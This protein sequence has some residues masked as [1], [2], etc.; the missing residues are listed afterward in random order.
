MGKE[1]HTSLVDNAKS[2]KGRVAKPY[3][4]FIKRRLSYKRITT[5]LLALTLAFTA[6][7]SLSQPAMALK[8]GDLTTTAKA[9]A[10]YDGFILQECVA[11]SG[12][13]LETNET[14]IKAG[15]VVF[16]P[17]HQKV[18]AWDPT[19]VAAHASLQDDNEMSCGEYDEAIVKGAL[20]RL[21]ID[22]IQFV[23]SLGAERNSGAANCEKGSGDF[24]YNSTIPTKAQVNKVIKDKTGL[25]MDKPGDHI[26]YLRSLNILKG[27]CLG[28]KLTKAEWDAEGG[29]TRYNIDV[30][31][32][33]HEYYGAKSNK[34]QKP[35]GANGNEKGVTDCRTY[36]ERV[37]S[38]YPAY[39][40]FMNSLTNEQRDREEQSQVDGTTP[41][42]SDD[43]ATSCAIEGTGW[44]IC[45]IANTMA[46]ATDALY[47][48][49][50]N[51]L[52]V[53]PL[54]LD[55]ASNENTMY[56][57]WKGMRNVANVAFVVAFL[58][59]IFS[60]L[61]GAGVSNYGV[62]KMLPR[63]VIAAI[64]V[65]ISYWVTAIAVDVS[66]IIGSTIYNFLREGVNLGSITL[67]I[68]PWEQ[69]FTLLLSGGAIV[70][71]TIATKAV[72]AA[73]TAGAFVPVLLW[74]GLVALLMAALSLLV[75]F[76]VLALRQALIIILIIL[77]PLAFVAFLLP[78]TEKYF[79]VWRK[80]L[81]TLLIFYPLFSVLFGG[82]YIAGMVIIGSAGGASG[83]AAVGLLP[84]LGLAV[85]AIPL[86]LTPLII[87]FS[88]GIMG[89]VAGMVNNRSKG[90]IDRARN[91]RNRKANLA[92]HETL[93]SKNNA[94]NPFGRL[95]RR[96][97][98]SARLDAMRKNMVEATN[99]EGFASDLSTSERMQ[100]TAGR[101][102]EYGATRAS[103]SAIAVVSEAQSKAIAA[104][105]ATM[106]T[107]GV[108]NHPTTG[109]PGL[110]SILK[111]TSQSPERRAAA[112][113]M[114]MKSG[115]DN[116]IHSAIN[117]LGGLAGA[118]P[119]ASEKDKAV[120]ETIQQQAATD[121]APRKPTSI[122]A[123]DM[124]ALNKGQF[125]GTFEK[126][127]DSRMGNGKISAEALANTSADEL[128][129][130]VASINRVK[131]S[132]DPAAIKNLQMLKNDINTYIANPS[133]K[134]PAAEILTRMQ[135]IEG[136]I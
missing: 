12:K 22:P 91:T 133:T 23:C 29:N 48:W 74:G 81:T 131:G 44:I 42:G 126:S 18:V 67:N 55:T 83:D 123:G 116:E 57:A 136:N 90:L 20:K 64:L 60:Q 38:Y 109:A 46:A 127:M 26:R 117:E 129:K 99:Q 25:D 78:N 108:A 4:S 130:M 62:K 87:K 3:L 101:G 53:Q 40:A 102:H 19:I 27:G 73:G 47:G 122:G 84:I 45:P 5:G 111:D 24:K 106:S 8:Y 15:Q 14:K 124:S 82:S 86:A 80:S 49:V 51:F 71:A 69:V 66:N 35:R 10:Y 32:D 118:A 95:Y 96:S 119:G 75:A 72:V 103:A 89:T 43:G 88:S 125:N 11:G 58:I 21:G 105:K 70:T 63:L 85:M 39:S 50:S 128:D 2:D 65:N 17:V 115:S 104:E 37:N 56:I 34:N 98:N 6:T 16:P 28:T 9:T 135:G 31:P 132:G 68:N 79:G 100:Q 52:K 92:M 94:R 97:Q 93:G 13:V 61:S 76:F 54:N 112:A 33:K 30:Y 36:W 107:L 114:I 59:I 7:I 121:L 134:K 120:S 113:G 41:P 1:N 77:S 110:M